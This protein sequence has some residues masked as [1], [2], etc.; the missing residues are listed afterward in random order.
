M[1]ISLRKPTVFQL[2]GF[3]GREGLRFSPIRTL[4]DHIGTHINSHI[5]SLLGV[6]KK[7]KP[8]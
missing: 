5:T 2:V 8:V 4:F 7:P 3:V 6:G 1:V